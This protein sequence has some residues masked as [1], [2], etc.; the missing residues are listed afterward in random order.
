MISKRMNLGG[1]DYIY[2]PGMRRVIVAD[3]YGLSTDSKPTT[4]IA[5]STVFYEM[6][7]QAAYMFDE[8]NA[9]WHAL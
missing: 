7:T 6:D 4:D 1:T 5:N 3:M 8:D 9:T 2:R